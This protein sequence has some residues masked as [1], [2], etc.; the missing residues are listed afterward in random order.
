MSTSSESGS[1]FDPLN[2]DELN[3]PELLNSVKHLSNTTWH[4]LHAEGC[5]IAI[6]LPPTVKE[7]ERFDRA[8]LMTCL[9]RLEEKGGISAVL[10]AIKPKEKIL[11]KNLHFLGF[12][13]VTASDSLTDK[14]IRLDYKLLITH[15]FPDEE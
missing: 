13:D 11:Q 5:S 3:L 12:V 10:V 8:G 4:I 15:L 14:L 7:G 1:F 6:L 2:L 9:E